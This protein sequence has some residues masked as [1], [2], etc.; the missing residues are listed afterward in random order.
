MHAGLLGCQA[1]VAQPWQ[2][3][4]RLTG[5]CV[6]AWTLTIG[7]LEDEDPEVS[8][9]VVKLTSHIQHNHKNCKAVVCTTVACLHS[10]YALGLHY[11]LHST[12]LAQA[13]FATVDMLADICKL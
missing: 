7:M 10:H 9:D 5:A 1:G 3:S 11:L 12:R 8:S 4:S 13:W 6:Q 2:G